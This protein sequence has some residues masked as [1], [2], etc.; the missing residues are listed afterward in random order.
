MRQLNVRL[1]YNDAKLFA[2][3]AQNLPSIQSNGSSQS[4]CDTM[5][6]GVVLS[7]DTHVSV[8]VDHVACILQRRWFVSSSPWDSLVQP[9]SV[10]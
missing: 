6:E 9:S 8:R 2:A 3:I 4:N 7:H 5:V 10:S 1:S